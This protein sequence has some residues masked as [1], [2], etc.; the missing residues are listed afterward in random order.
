M[1]N[2]LN[3]GSMPLASLLNEN[4]AEFGNVWLIGVD[5]I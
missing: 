5:I 1:G 3:L 2:V 4:I